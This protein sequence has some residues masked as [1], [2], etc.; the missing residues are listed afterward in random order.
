MTIGREFFEK[1][2]ILHYDCL[3]YGEE[4]HIAEQ[5]I[6]LSI[7][8]IFRPDIV[9]KHF[10]HSVTKHVLNR[11]KHHYESIKYIY[12]KYFNK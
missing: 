11:R 2:G 9:V 4:I 10:E 6:T 7:P 3:I 1:G 8:V 12:N 5:A